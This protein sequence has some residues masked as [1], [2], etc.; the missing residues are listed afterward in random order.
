[1]KTMRTA[2]GLLAAI[3]LFVPAARS[4]DRPKSS[5]EPAPG[6]QVKLQIVL[7]EMDGSKKV[8]SLPYIIHFIPGEG[9]GTAT[10]LRLGLRVPIVTGTKEGN[11]QFTYAEVGT[12]IDC[13][14]KVQADGRYLVSLTVERTSA[15]KL[16][17]D[18]KLLEWTSSEQI[19]G[20]QPIFRQFRNSVNLLLRD[21]QPLQALFAADPLNGHILTIDATLTAEK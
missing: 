5:E 3:L 10:H 13:Y 1:M 14:G 2:T 8:S 9:P 15:Y 17:P 4:Q 7:S 16:G 18:E 20:S 11:T 21:G 12:N 6:T 19:L